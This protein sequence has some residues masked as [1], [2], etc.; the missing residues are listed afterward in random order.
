METVLTIFWFLGAAFSLWMKY[1]RTSGFT[2][3]DIAFFALFWPLILLYY[4]IDTKRQNARLPE[5]SGEGDALLTAAGQGDP[6]AVAKVAGYRAEGAMA[7][8][9]RCWWN[10]PR[11][12]R[13]AVL[14]DDETARMALFMHVMEETGTAE[15]AGQRVFK[16]HPRYGDPQDTTAASGEDRPLPIVLK[17]RVNRYIESRMSDGPAF[18]QELEASTSFNAHVRTKLQLDQ[19]RPPASTD[20]A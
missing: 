9:I 5:S 7:E 8:D 17:D 16:M 6:E 12:T 3:I 15:V 20:S 11:A 2:W 19:R 14:E 13:H 10:L 4:F 18:K 1:E